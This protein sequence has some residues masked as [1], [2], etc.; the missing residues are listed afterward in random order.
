M[1]GTVF[2]KYRILGLLA[3]GGMGEVCLAQLV[4]PAGYVKTLVVKRLLRHLA[5]E[6]SLVDLFLNEARLAA[7]FDHPNI[8]QIFEL[9]ETDGS[10][11]IAMEYVRGCSAARLVT[12][13]TEGVDPR[14]AVLIVE[15]ALAGLAY[16][17]S[18][19]GENGEPLRLVH[20]DVSP[21]NL[22]VSNEGVVKLTDF[23]IAR[24]A[25]QAKTTGGVVRGKYRYMPPEQLRGETVDQRADI[26]AMGV[27]LYE[28][29][30]GKHPFPGQANELALMRAVQE[31]EPVPLRRAR[32][33]LPA[34][35]EAVCTRALAKEP[36]DRYT[37]ARE[38][39]DAL[40]QI[41]PLWR[42][43]ATSA[44]LGELVQ[45]VTKTDAPVEAFT[46]AVGER[47]TPPRPKSRRGL[48]LALTL[49]AALVAGVTAVAYALRREPNAPPPPVPVMESPAQIA[50]PESAQPLPPRAK[51]AARS[52]KVVFQI[53]PWAEIFL[54][55]KRF[56]P[57]PIEPITLPVGTHVF[58]LRNPELGIDTKVNVRVRNGTTTLVK[59][60]LLRES[61][62]EK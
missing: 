4:G 33:D 23:G 35:L 53:Y 54:G 27:V 10:Y 13:H 22:L 7:L 37:S 15:Q 43:Q 44:H 40:A 38:M 28:L 47:P 52:G 59:R 14:L 8:I 51:D 5:A 31:N 32:L 20:R 49:T 39:A 62:R 19:T 57:T 16:V 30:S 60:D 41:R 1:E 2:G 17:H 26:Y 21:D 58:T 46:R 48:V 12:R 34:E 24:A 50:P 36:G 29:A 11:F 9:G 25:A 42:D 56:G 6:P 45:Q 3:T 61:G 18:R 55:T